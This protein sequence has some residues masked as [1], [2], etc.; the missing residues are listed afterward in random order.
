MRPKQLEALQPRWLH[1]LVEAGEEEAGTLDW[2]GQIKAIG[3]KVTTM[4]CMCRMLNSLG[5]SQW[6]SWASSSRSTYP[7]LFEPHS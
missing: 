5:L 3:I 6:K 2:A 4:P 1:V 7:Y